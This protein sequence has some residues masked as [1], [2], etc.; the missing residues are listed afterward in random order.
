MPKILIVYKY[1]SVQNYVGDMNIVWDPYMKTEWY[2]LPSSASVLLPRMSDEM[3]IQ[4]SN[5][6]GPLRIYS[7]LER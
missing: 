6:A 4:I 2:S 5:V 7:W 1:A 3:Q